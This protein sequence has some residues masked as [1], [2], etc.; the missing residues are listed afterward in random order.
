ML[1]SH[2]EEE[3]MKVKKLLIRLGV[4]L[5]FAVLMILPVI[6]M[7]RLSD[8]EMSKYEVDTA[9]EFKEA[10]YGEP[11]T[12]SRADVK[13]Y[14]T[15]SGTVTSDTY[16]YIRFAENDNS[17]VTAVVGIGDEVFKDK[18]VA[19]I[20]DKAVKSEYN[21]IVEDVDP[22]PGGSVKV[23]SFD[24]LKL[25]CYSDLSTINKIRECKDLQLE[26]GNKVKIE[27]IS[28]L[29]VDNKVKIVFYVEDMDYLYGQEINDLK[30]YTGKVYSDVLVIDKNCVY[31]KPED[32]K[33]YVRVLDDNFYFVREQEVEIGFETEELVCVLN[34]DEDTICDPGYKEFVET[35]ED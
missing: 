35:K 26:N 22:T 18:V 33:K 31:T 34:I 21:G 14:Y 29:I 19:Y 30:I 11:K 13:M 25:T 5:F 27:E 28:N 16:K 10:A 24:N 8:Q 9:F 1:M 23:R 7:I 15:F 12:V 3:N 6:M 17:T 4:F 32:N 2:R 20:G